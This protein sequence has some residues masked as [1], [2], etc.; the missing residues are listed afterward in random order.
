MQYGVVLFY[1]I[2]SALRAEKLLK[3]EGI[4]AKP[5]PVPRHL[6]SDCGICLR[7]EQTEEKRIKMILEEKQVEIQGIHPV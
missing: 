2:S 1:S 6:S 4:I 3:K 7:F 5:I